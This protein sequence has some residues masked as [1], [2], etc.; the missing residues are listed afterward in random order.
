[1][2]EHRGTRSNPGVIANQTLPD[3]AP[4][5]RHNF[6]FTAGIGLRF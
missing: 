3:L 6:Q 2:I 5:T 1:L 4:A